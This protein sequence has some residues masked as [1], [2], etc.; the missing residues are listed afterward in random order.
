M[1]SLIPGRAAL[2]M[3][4]V[5]LVLR[6]QTPA[7]PAPLSNSSPVVSPDGKSIAF[8]SNRSGNA[9]LFVVPAAGGP[10]RQLTRTPDPEGKAE[11]SSDGRRLYYAIGGQ[12]LSRF[13]AVDV[14][15]GVTKEIGAV[16]SR[17]AVVSPD[18]TRVAYTAGSWQAS[19][20]AIVSLDGSGERLL[21]TTEQTTVAWNPRF[22]PDGRW[23]AFTGQDAART[24]Q[25]FVVPVSGGELTQVTRFTADQGRAQ[26]PAWSPDGRQVAF[27]V[28][29]KGES[30]VWRANVDGTQLTAVVVADGQVLNEVPAWF[31]DGRRLA[32]QSTRSGRMEIWTVNVDG[33]D[34]KQITGR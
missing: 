26:V 4:A 21:T 19:Q 11:W 27:Q 31:P 34:P 29:R 24:L 12:D 30:D 25:I 9:D 8:V 14:A 7:P 15:T 16:R 23:I 6:P 3:L 33:T 28:N 2:P 18:G 5:V 32:F 13:Y 1:T 17:G 10:E 20:L 22:S